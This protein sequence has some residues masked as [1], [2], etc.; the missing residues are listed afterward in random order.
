M[1]KFRFSLQVLLDVRTKQEKSAKRE[2]YAAQTE[3]N[4]LERRL[5]E[6]K[7]ESELCQNDLLKNAQKS[8]T[9]S[10]LHDYYLRLSR[11]KEDIISQQEKVRD[12]EK[13]CELLMQ[14]LIE[15]RKMVKML[16]T[17]KERRY[18]DYRLEAEREEMKLID[19]F[20]NGKRVYA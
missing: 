18:E 3:L 8:I 6:L 15:I 4:L 2:L 19:D 11:L 5:E 16:E 14:K 7:K 20:L 10:R 1:K 17:L 9:A 13:K 12:A